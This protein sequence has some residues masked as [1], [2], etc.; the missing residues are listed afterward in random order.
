MTIEQQVFNSHEAAVILGYPSGGALRVALRRGLKIPFFRRGVTVMFTK[1]AIDDA[2][3][4]WFKSASLAWAAQL[5]NEEQM[6]S[7]EVQAA[8][9]KQAAGIRTE[10]IAQSEAD[11]LK[12]YAIK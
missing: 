11:Y 7:A 12:K 10:V 3:A 2:L 9:S 5:E 4:A 1:Q 6:E 8:L